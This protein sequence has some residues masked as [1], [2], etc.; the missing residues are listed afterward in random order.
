MK[1]RIIQPSVKGR[2]RTLNLMHKKYKK[3]D[4]A[5][6][7]NPETNKPVPN[8]NDNL[9]KRPDFTSQIPK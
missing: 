3:I 9:N 5:K 4:C 2:M 6:F 7:C 1:T 8:K